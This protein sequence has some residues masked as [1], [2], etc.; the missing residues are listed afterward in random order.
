MH[1]FDVFSYVRKQS[2]IPKYV[3]ENIGGKCAKILMSLI[4]SDKLK[5]VT[6]YVKYDPEKIVLV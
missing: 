2:D 3:D 5:Y 4:D 1:G 6:I